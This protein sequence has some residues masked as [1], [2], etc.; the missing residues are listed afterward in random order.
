MKSAKIPE[1]VASSL[2]LRPKGRGGGVPALPSL[3]SADGRGAPDPRGGP[4]HASDSEGEAP[5]RKRGRGDSAYRDRDERAGD[6]E[7]RRRHRWVRRRSRSRSPEERRSRE[8]V[9]SKLPSPCP[10]SDTV[11]EEAFSFNAVQLVNRFLEVFSAESVPA[12][13]KTSLISELFADSVTVCSLKSRRPLLSS[14]AALLES[15][16][17]VSFHA[18]L[19]SRRVFFESRAGGTSFCLDLHRP[20]S[21]PG[22]GDPSRDGCLLY[23]C[24]GSRITSV[25]GGVDKEL[26]ASL[27]SLSLAR[28]RSSEV[29][30]QAVAVIGEELGELHDSQVHFH[31]YTN[32]EVIGG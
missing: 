7:D 23:R 5:H 15:F 11:A 4:G 18:A 6:D 24:E 19:A 14:R 9:A 12:E 29:W 26:L 10:N 13:R 27:T 25:W 17:R 21:A 3:H 20:H 31:D 22:L 32:I 30:R 16:Q 1:A 8:L 2:S 28:V